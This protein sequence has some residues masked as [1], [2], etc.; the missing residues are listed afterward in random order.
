MIKSI[1]VCHCESRRVGTKQSSFADEI[2]TGFALAMTWLSKNYGLVTL[3]VNP[4]A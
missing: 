1:D 4:A 2:A 3:T